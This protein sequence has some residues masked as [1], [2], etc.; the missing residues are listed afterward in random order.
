MECS[1]EGKWREKKSEKSFFG[2]FLLLDTKGGQEE[3]KKTFLTP[4]FLLY[5]LG[6]NELTRIFNIQIL[7]E[8][9]QIFKREAS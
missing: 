2:F 3:E 5:L 6:D 9:N 4:T 1:F 8:A 7:D